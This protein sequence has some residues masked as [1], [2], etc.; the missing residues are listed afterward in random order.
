MGQASAF[1]HPSHVCTTVFR[2]SSI[3]AFSTVRTCLAEQ[4]AAGRRSSVGISWVWLSWSA[5]KV[6][7]QGKRAPCL[8]R[9]ST[10]GSSIDERT[11]GP[12]LGAPSTFTPALS[13]RRKIHLTDLAQCCALLC[14]LDTAS[15]QSLDASWST[16]R[17][18]SPIWHHLTIPRLRL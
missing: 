16:G 12:I 6:A 1:G 14:D 9:F 10:H 15:E 8:P 5:V 13:E 17:P 3:G 18:S 2:R 4:K 11:K 7:A